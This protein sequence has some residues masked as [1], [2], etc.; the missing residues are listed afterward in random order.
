[1]TLL[2]R[3]ASQTSPR[4]GTSPRNSSRSPC[5]QP[6]ST[7]RRPDRPSF[8]SSGNLN[9]NT[10]RFN[11]ASTL[12]SGLSGPPKRLED[13]VL[14]DLTHLLFC[15]APCLFLAHSTPFVPNIA[16]TM[17]LP[18]YKQLF[19]LFLSLLFVPRV[20]AKGWPGWVVDQS[21]DDI[22]AKDSWWTG[23]LNR[24]SSGQVR[25]PSAFP[26]YIDMDWT[27]EN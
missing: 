24:T 14:N 18:S 27:D 13:L 20:L 15:C 7:H 6:T 25:L 2:P 12:P 3:I 5:I 1:M 4:P 23:C 22:N 9:L 16:T 11:T 10:I 26:H 8:I 17:V 21:P 19:L